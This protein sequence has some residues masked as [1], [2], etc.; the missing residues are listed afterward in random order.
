M[1]EKTGII[2]RSG[3]SISALNLT[4]ATDTINR[5][6]IAPEGMRTPGVITK[7][8]MIVIRRPTEPKDTL[9]SAVTN[10]TDRFI[11]TGIADITIITAIK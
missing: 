5:L 11:I 3:T 2:N 10:I 4:G 9:L 6:V 8:S 7:N 1:A